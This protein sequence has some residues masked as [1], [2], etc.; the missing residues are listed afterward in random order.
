MWPLWF[1]SWFVV[2]PK[3]IQNNFNNVKLLIHVPK[4]DRNV[5][6]GSIYILYTFNTI[7]I[8]TGK[9]AF[10]YTNYFSFGNM[11]STF[12]CT[13][14]R[15]KIPPGTAGLV[16]KWGKNQVMYEFMQHV[17]GGLES[18]REHERSWKSFLLVVIRHMKFPHSPPSDGIPMGEVG[19][20][21]QW[22]RSELR[23]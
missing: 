9:Y 2:D 22:E 6:L 13:T 4:I 15:D 14:I 17:Y 7:I 21:E 19:E 5:G 20:V 8:I 18:H 1:W 3:L 16:W 10:K 12:R 11:S 23:M